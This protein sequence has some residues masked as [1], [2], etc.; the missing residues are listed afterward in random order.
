ME[1]RER[2]ELEKLYVHATQNYLRQLREGEGEQRLADQKAKV[3]QL[4]RMLDQRGAS[5]DPSASMLRR[6]S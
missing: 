5:T 4:S 1:N 3:L 6:H 2:H